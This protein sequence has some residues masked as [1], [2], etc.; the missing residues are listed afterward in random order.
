MLF[1]NLI[2]SFIYLFIYLHDT[3]SHLAGHQCSMNVVC[4]TLFYTPFIYVQS[5]L[6]NHTKFIALHTVRKIMLVNYG[7][8]FV[9]GIS[10]FK[11][12]CST[13]SFFI[14]LLVQ[15]MHNY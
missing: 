10:S 11:T 12:G 6:F 5:T 9:F 14:L 7:H 8:G 13:S 3:C 2:N 4:E 15:L 1:S